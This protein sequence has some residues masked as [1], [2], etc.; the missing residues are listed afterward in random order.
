[1]SSPRKDEEFTNGECKR[2]YRQPDVQMSN[3]LCRRTIAIMATLDEEVLA[4]EHKLRQA[5]EAVTKYLDRPDSDPHDIKLHRR[6][7][8]GLTLANA[9]Y[10]TL[11][12]KVGESVRIFF[13]VGGPNVISSPHIIGEIMDRVYP[14]GS[15]TSP[16]ITTVQT[17]VVPPG[18][19]TVLELKP[20][21][22]G[23]FRLVDHALIR[24]VRGLVGVLEV[25]GS[26]NSELFHAGP[27][28]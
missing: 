5:F 25:T 26:A 11:V 27:A 10:V 6:L 18:G 16:P 9:R 20:L 19:A 14:E 3:R 23:T 15:F 1:M 24:V 2:C 28:H 22:P 21:V 8:D 13:G 17:T 12:S 4:A 7:A